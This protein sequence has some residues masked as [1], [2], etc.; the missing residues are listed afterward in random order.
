MWTAATRRTASRILPQAVIS[1]LVDRLPGRSRRAG[2][3]LPDAVSADVRVSVSLPSRYARGSINACSGCLSCTDSSYHGRPRRP[4]GRQT[5]SV[6]GRLVSGSAVRWRRHRLEESQ[7][8]GRNLQGPFSIRQLPP[9][10][11]ERWTPTP[12]TA[13]VALAR[14]TE[15]AAP[16][17]WPED[18]YR[19]C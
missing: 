16:W 6:S 18:T 15:H 13:P 17:P 10:L 9:P 14:T 11:T 19:W 5:A 3:V 8:G 7:T 2:S 4:I 12:A 1:L